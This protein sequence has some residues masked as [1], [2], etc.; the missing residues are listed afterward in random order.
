MRVAIISTAFF[1]STLPLFKYLYDDKTIDI[2]LYCLFYNRFLNCPGFD[3]SNLNFTVKKDIEA[4]SNSYVPDYLLDYLGESEKNMYV[5]V[6]K[7]SINYLFGYENS[8]AKDIEI[9]NY[10]VIHFI[11]FST[12]YIPISKIVK[13]KLV[14]SLHESNIGRIKTNYMFKNIIRRIIS[15]TQLRIINKINYFTFF[16]ENEKY[17]FINNYPKFKYCTTVIKFG[18]FET[19]QFIKTQSNIIDNG[20]Y[21]LFLGLIREYKGVQFLIDTINNSNQL[22]SNKFIIAGKNEIG[23]KSDNQ[24]IK[25]IDKF[26]LDHEMV[27]L[28]KNCKFLVLPYLSASQSGLP[29]LALQFSKPLIFSDISGLHEYLTDNYN[30]IMFE[31]GNNESL[32]TAILKMNETAVY[33]NL[34]LNIKTEP[35]NNRISWLDSKNKMIDV[36]KELFNNY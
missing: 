17:N 21:I 13:S 19:Y 5:Y 4:I 22:S 3:M 33:N 20:D 12:L 9:K 26:L 25:I 16:S 29:S 24:N 30:G 28:I 32:L 2:D 27:S 6:Y 8:L 7:F 34:V 1:E 15:D 10:D 31:S 23:I 14:L 11:G 35:F 36:Y 18:L